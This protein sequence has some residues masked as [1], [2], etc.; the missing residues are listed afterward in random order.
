MKKRQIKGFG[1]MEIRS[2]NNIKAG[3]LVFKTNGESG[4]VVH[5]WPVSIFSNKGKY[6]PL[7]PGIGTRIK[8]GGSEEETRKDYP[9]DYQF[10]VDIENFN[11]SLV[12]W[13]DQERR[14]LEA[15]DIQHN[16]S[17]LS[18]ISGYLEKRRKQEELLSVELEYPGY[19][20]KRIKEFQE[21]VKELQ[22]LRSWFH[23]NQYMKG[24]SYIG[25]IYIYTSIDEI[26]EQVEKT[27]KELQP[28]EDYRFVEKKPEEYIKIIKAEIK[29][30]QDEGEV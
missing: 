27:S 9:V 11:L 12:K 1:K 15:Q 26:I 22:K 23:E 21:K 8:W 5:T 24:R 29:I 20:E 25:Q 14:G 17:Q 4:E 2:I 16:A 6:E 3:T 28:K 10:A 19:I 7:K 30:L 18:I 13:R